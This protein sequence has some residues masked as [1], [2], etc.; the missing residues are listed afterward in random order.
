MVARDGIGI[1]VGGFAAFLI[2]LG[3]WYFFPSAVAQ[4]VTILLGLFAVFNLYFFRDPDREPPGNPLAVI[5]PADGRV[6]Q[7]V[8]VDEKDYF[9]RR[10]QR[11]SVFLSVFN[12]HV[13]RSPFSGTVDYFHYRTGKF[14]AAFK[15][16][17]SEENEQ[18]TIGILDEGGNRVLFKQIAGLIARRIICHYREGMTSR[19]GERMGLIRYGSRVDVF[20]SLDATVAVKVGQT[21]KAGQSILATFPSPGDA[22]DSEARLVT[23][24]RPEVT[25]S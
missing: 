5:S 12:V 3:L 15:H 17:A 6:T 21:V 24:P 11:I 20:V 25:E 16:E 13:N 22:R 4:A 10:V 23:T 9:H 18:T 7:I 14:L 8:E 1:I 2:S 19:A